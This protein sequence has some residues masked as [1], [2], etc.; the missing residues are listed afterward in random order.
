MD[1]LLKADLNIPM[2]KS[3]V[4]D[5]RQICSLLRMGTRFKIETKQFEWKEDWEKEDQ[6]LNEGGESRDARMARICLPAM[7]SINPDLKFTTEIQSD[8]QDNKI[9][10]LDFKG[11]LLKNGHLMHTYFEKAM[12]NQI[13]LMKR[14]A[15]ATRQKYTILS[16]ELTRRLSNCHIEGTTIQEKVRVVEDFTRQLKNSG[17][18]RSESREM[19]IS[20]IKGWLRKQA[21]RRREGQPFYRSARSTLA[22]RTKKKLTEKATWYKQKRKAEEME[23]DEP[24]VASKSRRWD[25]ERLGRKEVE[26]RPV[27]QAKS[28][29][30]VP[31]TWDGIL[32]KRLRHVEEVMEPI[33][34]WRIKF[35]ERAGVKLEE[36]LHKSNPWQGDDCGRRKCLLDESKQKSGKNLEQSCTRRSIIYETH[37]ESCYRAD[38]EE[39]EKLEI[40]EKEKAERIKRIRK[41]KYIGE[42]ARSAYERLWEHQ[43]QLEQLSPESHMLKHIVE[44][45]PEE[46]IEDIEFRA[47]IIKYT[48]SAFERQI[49]ESVLIQENK[50]CHNILNSK[51]EYN[52]CSIPRLTTKLGEKEI[53]DWEKR[54]EKTKMEEKAHEEEIKRKI[55]DIRRERNKYRRQNEKESQPS[56]RRKTGENEYKNVKPDE[57]SQQEKREGENQPEEP[58]PKRAKIAKIFTKQTIGRGRG[59]PEMGKPTPDLKKVHYGEWEEVEIINIDWE[60][61][62]Q[63][64]EEKAREQEIVRKERLELAERLEKGWELIRLS[65]SFIKENSPA[66]EKTKERKIEERKLEIEKSERLEIAELKKRKAQEKDIKDKIMEKMKILPQEK[67]KEMESNEERERRLDLKEAKE[68]LWRKWRKGNRLKEPRPTSSKE[69]LELKLKKIETMLIAI[70]KEK[71]DLIERERKEMIR[72]KKYIEE[73]GRKKMTG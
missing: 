54:R 17:F 18:S 42:S 2:L 35:V 66:W 29:M 59:D 30:F 50:D 36:M 5:I 10:T 61:R 73:K 45:H 52:R 31:Y 4:D 33:T 26:G 3:Y 25:G 64:Q 32:V 60:K 16:N 7:E 41:F 20:G 22:G 14:S 69:Q 62:I 49:R 39:I 72:R 19:V 9:P 12:K 24:K 28:V 13:L 51:S 6:E 47:K 38:V 53:K 40:G 23:D 70:N 63:D 1:I 27:S 71:D 46:K 21:R 68:N 8:F 57:R 43:H 48:R 15:M 58:K 11:W 55:Y 67:V 56:K 65:V 37:C 44:R 34:D